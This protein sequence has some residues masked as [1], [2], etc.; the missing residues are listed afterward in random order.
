VGKRILLVV[1]IAGSFSGFSQRL[2]L[3]QDA[4]D[5]TQRYVNLFL[6]PDQPAPAATEKISLFI[7]QLEEKKSTFKK[8]NDFLEY[9]FK[10]T[11]QRFLRHYTEYCT[12]A[13]LIEGG[14]YNCLTGTALYSLVLD[15]FN[16]NYK[17][18][19]TNYH[20]FLVI[21]T[22]HG[23]VLFEATDPIN[24]FV[25]EPMA[26]AKRIENYRSI[27]PDVGKKTCYRYNTDIYNTV[28]LE[29]LVGLM[30][31]NL[32]V[33]AYNNRL[34]S[35]SI[36]YLDQSVRFYKTSRT[37]EFTRI[38]FLTLSAGTMVHD[39]ER[40]ICLQQLKSLGKGDL[41]FASSSGELN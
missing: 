40:D 41:L 33:K 27:K 21:E 9:I 38:I 30:Y 36:N 5:R 7:C 4:N 10:K 8:D 28:S 6:K 23:D 1:L 11:H 17:I 34:L 13:E 25:D 14:V 12:F 24:G 2:A 18:T 22:N 16:I 32:S 35:T 20:I 3:A 26:V 39:A 37:D 19:E 15:H 31:Y 29:Q